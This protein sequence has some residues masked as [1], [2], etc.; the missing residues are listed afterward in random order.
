MEES[1]TLSSVD[2]AKKLGITKWQL[3]RRIARGDIKAT[4]SRRGNV[5]Y[6]IESADLD[7][8]IAAGPAT[9][10][11]PINPPTSPMMGVNEAAQ[12]LGFANDTIRRMCQAGRLPYIKGKGGKGQYRIPRK[13]V[14]DMLSMNPE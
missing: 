8:Y 2:A 11:S 5:H 13:A 6:T 1:T 4:L 10:L 7:A 3:Y 9:D 14:E 12:M